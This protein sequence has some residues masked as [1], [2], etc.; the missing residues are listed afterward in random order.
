MEFHDFTTN[1]IPGCDRCERE[2]R[3]FTS[4]SEREIFV[5]QVEKAEVFTPAMRSRKLRTCRAEL[6]S[7]ITHFTEEADR[8]RT[9]PRGG[10]SIRFIFLINKSLGRA[11]GEGSAAV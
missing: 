9:G 3:R 1:Q 11:T 5:H 10:I 6:L 4:L 8:S 2:W 7:K